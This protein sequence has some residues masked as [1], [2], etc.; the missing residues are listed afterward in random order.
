MPYKSYQAHSLVLK[1]AAIP[2]IGATATTVRV[3][4]AADKVVGKLEDGRPSGADGLTPRSTIRVGLAT[5]GGTIGTG[6]VDDRGVDGRTAV[7]HDGDP[8]VGDTG[9]DRK[10]EDTDGDSRD[11]REQD[12]NGGEDDRHE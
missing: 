8:V 4:D 5:A 12:G 3:E 6:S 10:S 1:Q 11:F 9:A 7:I 2:S